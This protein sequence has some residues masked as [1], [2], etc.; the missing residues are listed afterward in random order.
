MTEE[1]GELKLL[2][3]PS[4]CQ[5]GTFFRP[6]SP[7]SMASLRAAMKSSLESEW[8]GWD[9]MEGEKERGREG[10]KERGSEGGRCVT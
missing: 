1:D 3:D 6:S 8:R 5:G 4:S 9:C 7:L 2:D 10:G